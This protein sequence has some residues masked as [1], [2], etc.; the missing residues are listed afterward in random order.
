[1][2]PRDDVDRLYVSRKEGGSRLNS[3]EDNF[4]ASIQQFEDYI[5]NCRGRQPPEIIFT[6]ETNKWKQPE[7]KNWKENNC[8]DV[9]S[10]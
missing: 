5:V 2:H 9:L 1:M 3:I 7:K 10:D 4:D 8:I 6:W